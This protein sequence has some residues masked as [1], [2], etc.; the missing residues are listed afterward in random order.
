MS[1]GTSSEAVHGCGA[2]RGGVYEEELQGE[3][4]T[5]RGTVSPGFTRV[6]RVAKGRLR[7]VLWVEAECKVA[8][9]QRS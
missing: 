4:H 9:L 1:K 7:K 5:R 3:R 8:V 2:H 6:S